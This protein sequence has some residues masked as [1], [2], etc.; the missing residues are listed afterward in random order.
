MIVRVMGDGQYDIGDDALERLNALDP[1]A[2]EALEREDEA[3]LDGYLDEMGNLVRSQGKRL[4][5]DEL[6]PSDIVVPPSD[7]T[8]GETRKLL[9][10]QGFIPDPPVPA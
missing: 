9:S 4:P 10:E 3:E 1:Q 7:L 8:L 6:K 2:V 5:D